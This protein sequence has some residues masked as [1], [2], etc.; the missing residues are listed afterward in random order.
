MVK[1]KDKFTP[2]PWELDVVNTTNGESYFINKLVS[3][4]GNSDTI[5]EIPV[6]EDNGVHLE[7]Q[8]AN[9]KLIASAP[10]MLDV[11]KRAELTLAGLD[12]APKTLAA[13]RDVI[14]KATGA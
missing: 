13:I 8:L 10:D 14:A 3:E 2:G 1:S 11:L 12:G 6:L 9:A 4:D 5:A 7:T